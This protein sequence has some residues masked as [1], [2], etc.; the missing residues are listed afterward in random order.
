MYNERVKETLSKTQIKKGENT[1]FPNDDMKKDIQS[2]K[3]FKISYET[4]WCLGFE[5]QAALEKYINENSEEE[6]NF[7]KVLIPVHYDDM[8]SSEHNDFVELDEFFYNEF[9]EAPICSNVP[10]LHIP[11]PGQVTK[12]HVLEFISAMFPVSY[13]EAFKILIDL[14]DDML[15]E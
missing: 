4:A 2:Y 14:D 9:E 1:M 5:N 10:V 11:R 15:D 12:M 3:Y 7:D 13:I 8:M 6:I